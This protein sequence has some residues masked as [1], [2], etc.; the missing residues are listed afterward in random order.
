MNDKKNPNNVCKGC[1]QGFASKSAL[2]RHL[3]ASGGKCFPPEEHQD[4]IKYFVNAEENREKIIIL[5]GYI[6]GDFYLN[7]GL[8]DSNSRLEIDPESP[9]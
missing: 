2:F 3:R 1:N 9:K 5:Y 4:F 7:L 6:P 8:R